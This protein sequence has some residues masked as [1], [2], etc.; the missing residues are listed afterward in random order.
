MGSMGS[1][2]LAQWDGINE[3]NY[4]MGINKMNSM[5]SRRRA[6]RTHN[7]YISIIYIKYFFIKLILSGS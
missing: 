6:Q 3:M 5:G 7:K 4:G 2:K 1:M